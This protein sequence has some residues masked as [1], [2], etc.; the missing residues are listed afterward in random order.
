MHRRLAQRVKA[1]SRCTPWRSRRRQRSL[2]TARKSSASERSAARRSSAALNV[3]RRGFLRRDRR[4]RGLEVI[5]LRG[6]ARVAHPFAREEAFRPVERFVVIAR[7]ASLAGSLAPFDRA[8][9][10]ADREVE[11]L[12]IDEGLPHEE[13]MSIADLPLGAESREYAAQRRRTVVRPRSLR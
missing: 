7:L 12:G 1:P 11:T 3:R 10:M 4:E 13:R 9:C 8:A 5:V 2:R 6:A